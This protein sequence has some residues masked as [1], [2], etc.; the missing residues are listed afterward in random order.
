MNFDSDPLFLVKGRLPG[1]GGG[2]T[3]EI[4]KKYDF[5]E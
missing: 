3:P 1:R 4:G 5:L 2:G